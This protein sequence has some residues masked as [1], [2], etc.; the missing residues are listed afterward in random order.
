MADTGMRRRR[1]RKSNGSYILE[2]FLCLIAITGIIFAILFLVR[3]HSVSEKVEELE[4]RIQRYEDPEDPYVPAS[5]ASSQIESSRTDIY[6][7]AYAEGRNSV[8]GELKND[9]L[10]SDSILKTVAAFY[11]DDIIILYEGKYLFFPIIEDLMKNPYERD[12]YSRLDSGRIIYTDTGVNTE[13]WI[14]VSKFQGKILWDEVASDG[15]DGAMLRLGYRGYSVGEIMT[16]DTYEDNIEG[17]LE[18]DL[19]VGIY[20]L[21]QAVSDEEA[22]EEAE[23]VIDELRSYDIT[24]PVAIDIE[25]VGGDDGRGNALSVA[26][27]TRYS[28]TFLE[29]IREA[30][31]EPMIYGNLK[32]YLV[33]L[34][35]EQLEAYPK[36]FA[37]YDDYPY[38]PYDMDMWQYTEKGSVSGIKGDVDL[39]IRFVE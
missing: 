22:L 5:E 20:F 35:L 17:A 34:D 33:M 32:S 37:Y 18:N 14:D 7:E 39:N 29:A 2:I 3:Y 23:Y 4:A 26:E 12:S 19:K 21:S 8:L 25:L 24:G 6:N 10:G 30:G 38:W 27:R 9:M 15:I 31:Y 36:W 13:T 16:D 11:P 28:I 1:K